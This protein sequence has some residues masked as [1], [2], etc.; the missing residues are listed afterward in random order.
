MPPDPAHV[1]L[2]RGKVRHRSFAEA[3]R[4]LKR[5]RAKHKRK[6]RDRGRLGLYRCELCGDYHLG[7]RTDDRDGTPQAGRPRRPPPE[8][9][10]WEEAA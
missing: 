6:D 10:D 7:N 8:V 4:Q 1:E 2:C 5:V 9:D 3:A